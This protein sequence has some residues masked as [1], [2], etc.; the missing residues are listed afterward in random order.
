M[1][2]PASTP[3][4]VN[5]PSS[6]AAAPNSLSSTITFAPAI[7]LPPFRHIA[8]SASAMYRGSQ[9]IVAFIISAILTALP[10]HNSYI[11]AISYMFLGFIGVILLL[12]LKSKS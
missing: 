6:S 3:S 8:G 4:I 12:N 1:L 5:L 11:L 10:W 9:Q 7:A 2:A